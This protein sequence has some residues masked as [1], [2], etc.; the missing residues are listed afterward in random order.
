MGAMKQILEEFE[1]A[2]FKCAIFRNS[3]EIWCGYVGVTKGHSFYEKDYSKIQKIDVPYELTFSGY[4][5]PDLSLWWLGFDTGTGGVFRLKRSDLDVDS[6][7]ML[8]KTRFLAEQF[9]EREKC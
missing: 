6:E 2:G 9:K 5:G 4:R 8:E 3:M 7:Y 1:H